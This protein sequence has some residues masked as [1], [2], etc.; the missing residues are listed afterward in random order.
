[1][2]VSGVVEVDSDSNY[3]ALVSVEEAEVKKLLQISEVVWSSVEVESVDRSCA[4]T[5]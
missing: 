2:V 5:I 1:M 4:D 3:K